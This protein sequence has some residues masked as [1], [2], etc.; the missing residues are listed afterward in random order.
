MTEHP[1]LFSGPNVRAILEGRKTQTRR[2]IRPQPTSIT[3]H[4][5]EV[6][7]TSVIE[8]YDQGSARF[9]KCPY[10]QLGD[11][12]WV[13]ETWAISSFSANVA[14]QNK[15][16]VAY[17]VRKPEAHPHPDGMIHSLEWRSVDYETW[18]KYTQKGYYS[19]RPSIHMPRWASRITL[20]VVD[21]RVERVQDIGDED[22]FAEG[23]CRWYKD[24]DYGVMCD[25]TEGKRSNPYWTPQYIFKRLW[26]S[27]NAKRGYGW[28]T[29]CW[30]W[31]IE[32]KVIP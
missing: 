18:K 23:A 24:E 4:T 16:E 2:V 1:I 3:A 10:G 31:V 17:R 30:V 28:D 15:L 27:I 29:N 20:E 21:V 26:D 11:S 25:W 12:L 32:F 19:W 8:I 13:R 6:G 5:E 7:N 14:D 22:C 9:I